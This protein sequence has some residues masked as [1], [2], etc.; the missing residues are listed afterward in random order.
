MS[1]TWGSQDAIVGPPNQDWG[2]GDKLV[3]VSHE[4][5]PLSAMGLAKSAGSGLV[6]GAIDVAAT[7]GNLGQIYYDL[8][9]WA[10]SKINPDLAATMKD[11]SSPSEG[12]GF[13]T[14][15][16]L[17]KATIGDR[18]DYKP[19]NKTE[20]YVKS[21]AKFAPAS[22]IGPGGP[23]TKAATAV[24]GGSGMQAGG[25]LAELA[26]GPRPLGELAGA[27]TA[28]MLA[29][30]ALR[31]VSPVR[32]L[33]G[34]QSAVDTLRAEGIEPTAGQVTGSRVVRRAEGSLG[35][36]IGAGGAGTIANERVGEQF[37]RAALRRIGED[38]DRATPE[39][40]DRALTRI[41]RDFD[42][43]AQRNNA[44][45]DTQFAQE[46]RRI[47]TE[48]HSLVP[49][50]H[51]APII[52]NTINDLFAS[53]NA[54]NGSIPG[55]IYQSYRSRFSRLERG[56]RD[57]ELSSALGD[58]RRALD[59]TMERSLAAN[60]SPDLGAWQEARRQYRNAL[61]IEKA[62]TGAGEQAAS[63]I[64]SPAKLRSAL[65]AQNRRDY[66]RGQGD[67]ADLVR[68]GEEVLTPLPNSN[69]AERGWL[70][71]VPTGVMAGLGAAAEGQLGAMTGAF[72]GVVAPGLAGRAIMSSPGQAYLKNQRAIPYLQQIPSSLDTLVRAAIVR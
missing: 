69:T 8:A 35:E 11:L 39:V 50:S 19:E 24:L 38:A 51:R 31:A 49:E 54:H 70:H 42:G 52:E 28:P 14:S 71:A 67:F 7:P 41:G 18:F 15:E 6:E 37:T 57:P 43:L 3:S 61:I 10:L 56:T 5:K 4:T 9:H 23:A 63:G 34:R 33:P 68:A 62:A 59:D 72:G 17:K 65:T 30:G 27:M 47:E 48:Y 20:E 16:Q 60:S 44:R 40:V 64:L 32:Q 13:P 55:N 22:A 25:D 36:A 2:S 12:K 53:A 29:S 21:V 1:D 66:A 58:I 45:L 46:L 26:G